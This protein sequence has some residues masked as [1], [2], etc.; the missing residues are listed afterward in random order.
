MLSSCRRPCN[1]PP[2]AVCLSRRLARTSSL[3][4]LTRAPHAADDGGN[5][6]RG[7][8]MLRIPTKLILSL[9]ILA[10]LLAPSAARADSAKFD[11]VEKTL[12][13]GLRVVT[14]EDPSTPIVAVQVWYHVGS[15]NEDPKRQGFAHMFEHMMFRGTDKLGPKEHFSLIKQ[16]GGD[17]NAYT[18]FDQTVYINKLPSNQLELALWLESER[19]AFLKIDTTSFDT[20]RAVVEEERR[21]GLN[22]PYGTVAEK[23]LPHIF[24][25]HPYRWLPIGQIPHLRS[26]NIDELNQFWQTY[27][28]PNNATLVIVGAIKNDDAQKLAEKYFTWIPAGDKPPRVE[29][30]EPP[31]KE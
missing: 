29:E 27:Y 24:T 8:H 3:E 26:A 18:A 4:G 1:F 11:Y 15:K 21:L 16:V 2:R 14:L 12:S 25:K 20:E 31:Q 22:A 30:F 9:F 6:D 19:M 10:P 23:I 5:I 7:T 28:V 17:C 13:N